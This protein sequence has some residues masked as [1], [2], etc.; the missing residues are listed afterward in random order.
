MIRGCTE[1]DFRPAGPAE[2]VIDMPGDLTLG[3][4]IRSPWGR[5]SDAC[6]AVRALDTGAKLILTA[7]ITSVVSRDVSR[8]DLPRNVQQNPQRRGHPH[9]EE[10]R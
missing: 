5:G 9:R 10:W 4:W 8:I 1:S 2:T 7:A 3:L 6:L